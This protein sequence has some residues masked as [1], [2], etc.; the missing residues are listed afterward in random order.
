DIFFLFLPWGLTTTV[1]LTCVLFLIFL[2][3][4]NHGTK[5]GKLPPGPTPLPIFGNL[6]QFD[7]KNMVS[8]MSKVKGMDL[9]FGSKLLI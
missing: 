5:K 3:L 7:F 1:L 9:K 8:T 4:W 6:L 2:S